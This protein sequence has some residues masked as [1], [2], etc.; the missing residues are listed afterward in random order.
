MHRDHV[1]A[2]ALVAVQKSSVPAHPARRSELDAES[3]SEHSAVSTL[4]LSKPIFASPEDVDRNPDFLQLAESV[5][6][7]D[8]RPT[9]VARPDG[10]PYVFV[11]WR[12]SQ[13][14]RKPAPEVTFEDP[15][16]V[17][18]FQT[19]MVLPVEP[20]YVPA[21]SASRV[22]DYRRLE[23]WLSERVGIGEDPSDPIVLKLPLESPLLCEV[24]VAGRKAIRKA[25][26][27]FREQHTLAMWERIVV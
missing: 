26:K 9:R 10:T 14:D 6:G 21:H 25:L 7:I 20:N 12:G 27:T 1:A 16:L 24:P 2:S 15:F 17:R 18:L 19:L 3:A 23:I 4:D 8:P 13:R 22:F 5:E 11:Y